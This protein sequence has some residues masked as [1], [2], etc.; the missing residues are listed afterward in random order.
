MIQMIETITVRMA[1]APPGAGMR[2]EN[3]GSGLE[4]VRSGG[5]RLPTK[6][7]GNGAPRNRR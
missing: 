6:K 4:R 2:R 3:A 7:G 5:R 1:P